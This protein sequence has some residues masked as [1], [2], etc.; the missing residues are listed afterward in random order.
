M[1]TPHYKLSD[2]EKRCQHLEDAEEPSHKR[3]R[4]QPAYP[5]ITEALLNSIAKGKRLSDEHMVVASQLL[6]QQYPNLPGLFDP[7][8]GQNMSF[9]MCEDPFIQILYVPGE[10]HWIAVSGVSESE[11]CVY[12]SVFSTTLDSTKMQIATIMHTSANR[13]KRI[14]EKTQFQVGVV[15]CGLYAIA[16]ATDLCIGNNPASYRYVQH[17]MRPHLL[18]CFEKKLFTPFPS[19][20]SRPGRPTCEVVNVYCA[21][22]LPRNGEDMARCINCWEWF[23]HSCQKIPEAVFSD[24]SIKWKCSKCIADCSH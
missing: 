13:L 7:K 1:D 21:C 24:L 23:H 9:P 18:E 6:K 15:D 2:V 11:A 17:K 22:R 12:D 19:Q 20:I 3:R 16:Y 8:Q 10:E 4:I 5:V 14:V